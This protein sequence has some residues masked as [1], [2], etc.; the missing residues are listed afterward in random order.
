MALLD[1][2]KN[3]FAENMFFASA[4]FNLALVWWYVIVVD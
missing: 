2:F 1:E 4:G 3:G